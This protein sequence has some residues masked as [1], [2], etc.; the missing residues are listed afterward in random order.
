MQATQSA[1][2]VS[3]KRVDALR[4]SFEAWRDLTRGPT[5]PRLDEPICLSWNMQF[6]KSAHLSG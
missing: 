1:L 3:R 6:D 4:T 5:F 2:D